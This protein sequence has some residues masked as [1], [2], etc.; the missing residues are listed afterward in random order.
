MFSHSAF[1]GKPQAEKYLDN[2]LT[3]RYYQTL[4][5]YHA[6]LS[7]KA[8]FSPFLDCLVSRDDER[9]APL[10]ELINSNSKSGD[11]N[12]KEANKL[13]EKYKQKYKIN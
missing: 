1:A 2:L 6:Y 10:A 9:I 5:D 12:F 11:K 3:D 4:L 7:K 8:D 13:I